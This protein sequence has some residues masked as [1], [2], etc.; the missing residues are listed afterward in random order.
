MAF[1]SR[2][3]IPEPFWY[4]VPILRPKFV[5][6]AIFLNRRTADDELSSATILF[7]HQRQPFRAYDFVLN[8]VYQ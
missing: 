4:H 8:F 3:K 2:L 7:F 1:V 6:L 5:V